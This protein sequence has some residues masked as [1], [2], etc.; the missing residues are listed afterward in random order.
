MFCSIELADAYF[1]VTLLEHHEKLLDHYDCDEVD[2]EIWAK[3]RVIYRG[4]PLNLM[5]DRFNEW[6]AFVGQV[7]C[8]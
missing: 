4:H 6:N 1:R 7:I 8:G 2:H 3:I 5:I